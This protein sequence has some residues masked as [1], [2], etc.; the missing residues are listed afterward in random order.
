MDNTIQIGSGGPADSDGKSSNLQ[1]R[2]CYPLAIIEM[3][4][5]KGE[6]PGEDLVVN[7]LFLTL[8]KSHHG[9]AMAILRVRTRLP[10]PLL[11]NSSQPFILSTIRSTIAYHSETDLYPVQTFLAEKFI[12]SVHARN[13]VHL[14]KILV[15]LDSIA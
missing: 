6:P 3:I 5:E 15:D 7:G 9:A 12:E 10:Y 11:C 4:E 1:K 13:G 2:M 14:S 8:S